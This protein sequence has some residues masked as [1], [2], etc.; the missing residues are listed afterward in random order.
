MGN[1]NYTKKLQKLKSQQYL[2]FITL[3]LRDNFC[4]LATDYSKFK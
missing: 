2:T 1:P 3:S 4:I